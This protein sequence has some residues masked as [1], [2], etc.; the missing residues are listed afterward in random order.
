MGDNKFTIELYLDCIRKVINFPVKIISYEEAVMVR[1]FKDAVMIFCDIERFTEDWISA[2]RKLYDKIVSDGPKRILNN[3]WKS[4][5]R[6][7]LLKKLKEEGINSFNIHRPPVEGKSIKYPVFLRNE[8][9]HYGPVSKLLTSETDLKHQL[10][11]ARAHRPGPF[12]PL[13][14]EYCNTSSSD[15]RYHK[16]GAFYLWNTVVPRHL[17]F[18]D[19]WM[20]K[21]T[22][23]QLPEDINR[24]NDYINNNYFQEQIH[25]IFKMANIEYGRIDFA[26]TDRGIEVFEINTNPTMLDKGDL[27]SNRQYVTQFFLTNFT[28]VLQ[29]LH[30]LEL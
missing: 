27:Q 15:I 17:F 14:V 24:E 8:L 21:G 13:I 16:Y 25:N 1:S 26:K 20:V 9:D 18:C 5:R 22:N 11:S 6:Y 23:D 30:D 3:P 7:E 28:A 2:P 29:K 10:K 19:T 12:S 4:L